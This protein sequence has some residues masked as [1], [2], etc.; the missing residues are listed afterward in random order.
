MRTSMDDQ[1]SMKPGVLRFGLM[2]IGLALALG[3][4]TTLLDVEAP[5]GLG[6]LV[7]LLAA[8]FAIAN[9]IETHRRLP[10][11]AEKRSLLWGSWLVAIALQMAVLPLLGGA[12]PAG[13]LVFVAVFVALFTWGTL[14]LAYS[15]WMAERML[16][17]IEKRDQRPRNSWR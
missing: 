13:L 4:L 1:Q 2:F 11:P 9:F 6:V 7:L 12:M 5:S 10:L 15:N 17:G 3:L 16:K 14:A 8:Y